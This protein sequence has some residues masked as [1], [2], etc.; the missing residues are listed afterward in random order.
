MPLEPHAII[1][2][3]V[4][5]V[6]DAR[7]SREAGRPIFRDTEMVWIRYV[8]DP[9]RD[10]RAFAHEKAF[11]APKGD[12]RGHLTYA[13]RFPDHYAVFKSQAHEFA[14]GTPLDML[15]FLRKARIAELKAKHVTTVEALAG[16]NERGIAECGP[17]TQNEVNLTKAWLDK[18]GQAL[19]VAKANARTDELARELAE[20]KA[21][22]KA[23]KAAPAAD[24]FEDMD[25]DGLRAHL[26]G[27][28]VQVRANAS[29]DK[30]LAAARLASADEAEVA[31]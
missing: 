27:L 3:Y 23:G 5:P 20:L 21:E 12:D 8:G 1:E 11:M 22:M 9:T 13:E 25:D 18:S 10:L 30:L 28:G 17:A 6:E 24:R 2:F 4:E 14:V 16:L 31:A 15:P 19:E 7:A 29:R 26:A